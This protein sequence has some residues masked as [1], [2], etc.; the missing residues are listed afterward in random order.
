MRLR[1]ML[2][3]LLGA[4][5]GAAITLVGVSVMSFSAFAQ[6]VPPEC[7]PFIPG[8]APAPSGTATA[9][10]GWNPGPGAVG[11]GTIIGSI[12]APGGGAT[13][14]ASNVVVKGWAVDTT[15]QG[16][17]GID[18]VQVFN[19]LMGQGGSMVASAQVAQ[20]R[21]DVATA[22]NN[23]Y[24][25]ASGFNATIP[26]LSA[27][28]QTLNVYV[29]TPGRGWWYRPVQFTVSAVNTS[30]RP[31]V[32]VYTPTDGQT[33]DATAGDFTITGKATDPNAPA[34]Q[35]GISHV[36]VWLDGQPGQDG[37]FDLGAANLNA[38]GSWS[39]TFTPTHYQDIQ[40]WLYVI[41]TSS[42]TGKTTVVQQTFYITG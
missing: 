22:L 38:D 24:W 2:G 23:G 35:S 3:P 18:Q 26:S 21:Q 30:A 29:H 14:F 6:Q 16:W 1:G 32:Q 17:A 34:G 10:N 12:D 19:G 7:L 13:V 5:I 42:I 37:G 41:A 36:E 4:V 28:S 20:D 33:L 31:V 39:L 25:A 8:A 9:A 27:G 40:H 15:A 11:A